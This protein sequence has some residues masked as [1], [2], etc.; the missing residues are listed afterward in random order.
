MD[1]CT[2][3]LAALPAPVYMTDAKGRLA[4]YNEAAAE[5]WGRRPPQGETCCCGSLRLWRPEG[6]PLAHE[7]SVVAR[8]LRDQRSGTVLEAVVER[9]DGTRVAV[10]AHA[11]LLKDRAGRTEGVLVALTDVGV[12]NEDAIVRERL[13][14]IVASSQDAIVSKSLEGRITSWNE[15]AERIFGYAAEEM[16]GQSIT[17]IIPPELHSEEAQILARLRRGERIEHF[18]TVRVAKDGRRVDISLTVSP[19]RDRTGRIIGASKV[20]RDVTDR[21][22]DERL[23]RLLLA[24]LNHRVKNTLAMIQSIAAQSLRH[25]TTP[26]GFVDSFYG[27]LQALARAHTLLVEGRMQSADFAALVREQVLLEEG[28][29]PRIA[30]LGPPVS[31][32]PHLAVQLALVLHELAQARSARAAG[33]AG[34]DRM[35][36]LGRPLPRA[37]HLVAGKRRRR[38][39]PAPVPGVWDEHDRAR[40]RGERRPE[41]GRLRQ[42]RSPLRRLR[43]AAAALGRPPTRAGR[44]AGGLRPAPRSE[45]DGVLAKPRRQA[46]REP[47]RTTGASLPSGSL[48]TVPSACR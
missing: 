31:L 43:A 4:F 5:L 9:P 34:G 22:R 26:K 23:Q 13:A 8:A 48:G 46:M 12:R 16:I 21:K 24:E 15:G 35:E 25:A 7:E 28:G 14:A 45:D 33:G 36:R 44:T 32:E 20:A 17:R 39:R 11:T 29:D 41:R 10:E 42:G 1:R 27:R 40:P 18:D 47:R 38:P 2:D 37:A 19:L 6:G 30:C 3:L